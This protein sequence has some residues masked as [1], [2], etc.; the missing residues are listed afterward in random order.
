MAGDLGL[1]L[2]CVRYRG[3]V[4]AAGGQQLLH[5]PHDVLIV[6]HYKNS[7]SMPPNLA[8]SFVRMLNG[9]K[10]L[11]VVLAGRASSDQLT[12]YLL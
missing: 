9:K 7:W 4:I 12:H 8:H 2:D 11:S 1:R 3:D 6:V 10:W 5:Q